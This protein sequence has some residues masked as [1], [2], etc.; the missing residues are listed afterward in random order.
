MLPYSVETT[1]CV[2]P[3][4]LLVPTGTPL[5]AAKRE[6][7]KHPFRECLL[8]V[9]NDCDAGSRAR[10]GPELQSMAE[11]RVIEPVSFARSLLVLAGY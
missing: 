3:C 8:F 2:A 9:T 1:Q 6:I 5:E 11:G 7:A 4:G 10:R